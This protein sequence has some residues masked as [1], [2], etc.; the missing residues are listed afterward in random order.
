MSFHFFYLRNLLYS[1]QVF[2][3]KNCIRPVLE[4]RVLFVSFSLKMVSTVAAKLKT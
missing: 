2:F 3:K 1:E 4:A